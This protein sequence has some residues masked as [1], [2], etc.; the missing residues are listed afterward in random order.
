MQNTVKF[1]KLTPEQQ[2]AKEA[3]YKDIKLS[4]GKYKGKTLE[5]LVDLD[6]DYLVWL[7]KHMDADSNITPTGRAIIKYIKKQLF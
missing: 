1:T 6:S 4:F 3:A 2:A 5:E 7:C